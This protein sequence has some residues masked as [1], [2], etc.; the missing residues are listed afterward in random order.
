[1]KIK[2][3]PHQEEVLSQL[4]SGWKDHKTH[5]VSATVGFGKTAVAAAITHG[6]VS[7][8]LRVMFVA[9]YTTLV[10]QT[11]E[12]FMEYGLQQP[13][14]IWQNHEWTDPSNQIQIASADTLT[15]RDMPEIDVLIVDECHI[16]RKKLLEIID[17]SDFHT[18]GLSGT[19]FAKWMGKH[20]E[21]LVKVTTM[22]EMINNGYLSEFEIFAPTKPDLK[23]VKT[24]NLVSY[25]VDY[26]EEQ[27]A[28]IMNGAQIVGDIVSN[29]L[30]HGED[31]PTICFAVNVLHANH[32]TNQF[33][34]SGV[35]AEVMTAD[36]PIDERQMII[37][38]FEDG[39][40]KIICNVGV[41][42]AGFDSDV[43]CIIYARPT[44]S[45]MRW[46][47]C[48]GRGL[49][50]AEGKKRC[51][52]F[53]HSGSV[54]RLGF[55]DQIEY[56]E[57]ISETDG[58]KEQQERKEKEKLEKK[59]KE[60]SKCNFMKPAGVYICPKCGH[61][62]LAGEDVEVDESRELEQLKGKK[63]QWTK[64]EKQSWYSMFLMH[65]KSKGYKEGW[66]ANKYKEKFG[67]W[68][69]NLNKALKPIS[70]EFTAYIKHLNIKFAK[71][72]KNP[73]NYPGHYAAQ[74]KR[75]VE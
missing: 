37:K 66:A 33:N 75:L 30:E 24:S 71:G 63:R 25:G 43:R 48:L 39:I 44:K 10:N 65:C 34:R 14:I 36:T 35:N 2:L 69:K 58:M 54:H 42:V 20:Y 26:N 12:K 52:I 23:G 41:L 74:Q 13:G 40:T 3:R 49:R 7:R 29:W 70:P 53:D 72:R 16:R 28:E 5:L 59:P 4:R 56:D 15:R 61:K 47:Q 62:P 22:R 6:F 32:L 57:L 46:I 50:T 60:C 64:E 11:A 9:P 8:G 19:P 73:K 51:L 17:N 55:P 45:E 68:P 67:V 38:R 21:H 18:I 27:I 1:M 31:E